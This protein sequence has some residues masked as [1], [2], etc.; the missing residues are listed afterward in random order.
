LST[1]LGGLEPD[2]DD[3]IIIG[4]D[5][6]CPLDPSLDKKGGILIP[7]QHVINS[8]ETVQSEFSLHD[9]WRIRTRISAAS[10]GART[11]LLYFVDWITG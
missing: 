6:N 2:S 9:I 4:G 1:T 3:N 11:P 8:I 5:F 10:R 7:Q